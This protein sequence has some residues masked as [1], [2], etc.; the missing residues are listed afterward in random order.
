ME[1]FNKL[2]E[3]KNFD[4][5]SN[6]ESEKKVLKHPNNS[7]PNTSKKKW[8]KKKTRKNNFKEK[9]DVKFSLS[10]TELDLVEKVMK[11]DLKCR[12]IKSFAQTLVE[13]KKFSVKIV[14]DDELVINKQSGKIFDNENSAINEFIYHQVLLLE[15]EG[16]FFNGEIKYVLIYKGEEILPPRNLSHYQN[17]LEGIS[18]KKKMDSKLLE[19]KLEKSE[20]DE[21]INEYKLKPIINYSFKISNSEKKHTSLSHLINEI[22]TSKENLIF[23]KRK[24]IKVK[25]INKLDGNFKNK[26]IEISRLDKSKCLKQIETTIETYFKKMNYCIITRRNTKFLTPFKKSE[27]LKNTI[28]ET[29]MR[30]IISFQTVEDV[31]EAIKLITDYEKRN[32]FIKDLRWLKSIG[33][34]LHFE[35]NFIE[36][37]KA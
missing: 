16:E 18:L 29:L 5:H 33:I 23:D 31:N 10:K 3:L 14:T 32:E 30:K 9:I 22:K 19:K 6:L 1:N 34:I 21:K 27:M 8:E 17:T 25:N 24:E 7:E 15:N 11:N 26:I 36:I 28:N 35:D 37:N 20:E 12:K 13:K 4:F 2:N